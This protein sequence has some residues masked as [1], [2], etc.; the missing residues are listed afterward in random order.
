MRPFLIACLLSL[1][2][3]LLAVPVLS[4][5]LARPVAAAAVFALVL[6]GLYGWAYMRKG[7]L[8]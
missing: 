5:L 7:E 2:L 1:A 4:F 6:V 8:G 3:W